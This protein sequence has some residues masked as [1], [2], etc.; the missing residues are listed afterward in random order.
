MQIGGIKFRNVSEDTNYTWKFNRKGGLSG[1]V[2]AVKADKAS[3]DSIRHA[4]SYALSGT[5][6]GRIEYVVLHL[7]DDSGDSWVIE[8]GSDRYRLFKNRQAVDDELQKTSLGTVL[9]LDIES[10]SSENQSSEDWY[11]TEFD[12]EV[13]VIRKDLLDSD[14]LSF[15]GKLI[16]KKN[17]FSNTMKKFISKPGFDDIR[18]IAFGRK[19]KPIF[20][21]NRI[22]SISERNIQNAVDRNLPVVNHKIEQLESEIEILDKVEKLA[23]NLFESVTNYSNK[24]KQLEKLDEQLKALCKANGV[25]A[26]PLKDMKFKWQ[27]ILEAFSKYRV[28]EKLESTTSTVLKYLK[29]NSS[30]CYLQFHDL[31]LKFLSEDHKIIEELESSLKAG[32]ITCSKS[33]REKDA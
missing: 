21:K 11:V 12:G 9:D 8:R 26:L 30:D 1:A 25:K 20:E 31:M 18:L 29:E 28:Y 5:R 14:L 15:N 3:F 2:S 24:K 4:I 33:K 23:P 13:R 7:L 17:Y 22:N 6:K 27:D 10:L 19:L 32:V 16:D